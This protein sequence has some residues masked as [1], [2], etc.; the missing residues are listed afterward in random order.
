[1]IEMADSEPQ[2]WLSKPAEG[3]S[4]TDFAVKGLVGFAAALVGVTW[5]AHR[6]RR[7]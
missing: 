7:S 1:M 6:F 5:L 3:T 4:P 2:A